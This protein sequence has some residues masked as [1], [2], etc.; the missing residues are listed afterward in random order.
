[1]TVFVSWKNDSSVIVDSMIWHSPTSESRRLQCHLLLLAKELWRRQMSRAASLLW[2]KWIWIW[3]SDQFKVGHQLRSS[4]HGLCYGEIQSGTT[5]DY[6]M[7]WADCCSLGSLCWLD[8]INWIAASAGTV[9]FLDRNILSKKTSYFK[10]YALKYPP[11]SW[12]Q[13]KESHGRNS[14]EEILDHRCK[15]PGKESYECV[16]SLQHPAHAG[17]KKRWLTCKLTIWFLTFLL[18]Y[19]WEIILTQ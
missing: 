5:D 2:L 15:F 9:L 16:C 4:P 8:V 13:W 14:M 12:T 17:G 6:L 19:M 11:A 10:T 3:C 18:W 1:M 7:S